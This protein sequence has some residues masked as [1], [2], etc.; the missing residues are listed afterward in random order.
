M[1]IFKPFFATTFLMLVFL[2]L[3]AQDTEKKIQPVRFLLGTY[4][5]FGGDKVAEVY[6]TN[7]DTQPVKAGQG[8]T[9]SA[10]MQFQI[11]K[12]EKFLLRGTVGYKFVTTKADNANI[13]LTRIPLHFTGNFM[14]TEK[15]RLG[16]GIVL[17]QGIKFK[18]GGLGQDIRFKN[19]SGP[20]FEIAYYGIGISY[21]AM[22]YKDNDGNS[23]SANSFGITVSGVIPKMK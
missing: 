18:A 22:K 2:S 23:Y 17:H 11:P 1:K 20:I 16:A 14:A 15:L 3:S 9:V 8:L 6:F 10:G 5:E 7:G 12:A 21:T 19:A 13:T 4:F